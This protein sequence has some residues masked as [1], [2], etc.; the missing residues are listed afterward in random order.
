MLLVGVFNM[1]RLKMSV[2]KICKQCGKEFFVFPYKRNTAKY[3][4]KKCRDKSFL[5]KVLRK[6]KRCGKEFPAHLSEIRRGGAK[7][8]SQEC[9]HKPRKII[10]KKNFA[11]LPLNNSNSTI[12]DLK[13][14]EKV[15]EYNW[16]VTDCG[17]KKYVRRGYKKGENRSSKLNLLHRFIMDCPINKDIDHIDGDTLNNLKSNLRLCTHQQNMMN[18]KHQKRKLDGMCSSMYKGVNFSGGRWRSQISLNKKKIH[19]GYYFTELEAAYNYDRKS[20]ELFGEFAYPN[21]PE[22]M[23]KCGCCDKNFYYIKKDIQDT[24][25]CPDCNLPCHL[26]KKDKERMENVGKKI[27]ENLHN[28][29]C[30]DIIEA[31]VA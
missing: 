2:K 27:A 8:C 4:S 13:S 30:N 15:G 29:I 31:H 7:Y 28:N 24:A 25:M 5:K 18:Q 19:I 16:Y 6:C 17:V 12:I 14:V 3:C 26:S 20:V 22:N 1:R 9:R 23:Y 11:I 21:F 10:I